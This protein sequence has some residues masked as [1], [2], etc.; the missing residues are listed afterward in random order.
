MV[1]SESHSY[2]VPYLCTIYR[3]I[4]SSTVCFQLSYS[5]S[6]HN[7]NEIITSDI[8]SLLEWRIIKKMQVIMLI[9]ILLIFVNTIWNWFVQ[10]IF[11]NH[12]IWCATFYEDFS[13]LLQNFKEIINI[14][15]KLKVL[16]YIQ[17]DSEVTV[18]KITLH[19]LKT[20][21]AI[22]YPT[23]QWSDSQ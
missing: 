17:Q 21:G 11:I 16:Y 20:K 5:I 10:K 6:N 15:E 22:L 3:Y 9:F 1:M 12:L 19:S 8:F 14:L 7:N 13:R 2:M 23:R 18:N 4:S